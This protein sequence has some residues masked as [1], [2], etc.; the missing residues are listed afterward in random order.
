MA[1]HPNRIGV[2]DFEEKPHVEIVFE[3]EVD[4][5]INGWVPRSS[6]ISCRFAEQRRA[7]RL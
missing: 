6:A 2:E 3:R 4:H 7:V 1:A 5:R